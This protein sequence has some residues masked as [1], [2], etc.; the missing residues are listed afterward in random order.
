MPASPISIA[1]DGPASSGKGTV[2]RM[3]ARALDLPYVDTGAMYRSVGLRALR[4][5]VSTTGGARLGALAAALSFQFTWDGSL[6][7]VAVDGEDLTAAIRTEAVGQAASDVAVVPEVRAALLD[8]QRDLARAG[9]VMDGRDI[10]TVVLPDADLKIYLDASAEVRAARR[11]DELAARGDVRP[12]AVV[13]AD[14]LA[15]DAQDST[16]AHAPLC[17]AEDAVRVDSTHRSPQ[18][19]VEEILQLVGGIVSTS[20]HRA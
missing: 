11:R 4:E 15:R 16:R 5:G 13:L 20:T 14:I 10:G 6:L 2:A 19:V 12:L 17:A 18:E 3:V 1:I 9:A 7:R 8:L